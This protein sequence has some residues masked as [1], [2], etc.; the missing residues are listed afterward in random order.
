[1]LGAELSRSF[2]E[3]ATRIRL[4]L[5]DCDGVLTDAGVYYSADGEALKRFS[6]RDGMGVER[7]RQL[8]DVETGI[9]TGENSP[10]VA[11]RAEKLQIVELHLGAKNKHQVLSDIL[12]RRQLAPEQVAYIGDDVNDQAVMQAV[13]LTA[14][15]AD[16]EDDILHIA[17]Y[18]CQK[19]G[20][21]GAFREFA[22]RIIQA[23]TSSP[24]HGTSSKKSILIN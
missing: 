22:E 16:A 11:R 18:I 2:I 7:L 8:A 13:G 4:L 12:K 5:T 21:H 17:D 24:T 23:K 3:K 14:C 15:P 6:M 19:P 1:M 20:G 9:V 10:I